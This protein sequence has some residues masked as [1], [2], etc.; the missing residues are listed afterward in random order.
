[1]SNCNLPTASICYYVGVQD[2]LIWKIPDQVVDPLGYECVIGEVTYT[3]GQIT[4]VVDGTG[5][6]VTVLIGANDL[7]VGVYEGYIISNTKIAGQFEQLSLHVSVRDT[8]DV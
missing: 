4:A 8:A 7:S 5:V 6:I 3:G 2:V 1:M